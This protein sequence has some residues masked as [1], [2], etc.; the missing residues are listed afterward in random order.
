MTAPGKRWPL[1]HHAG[2]IV[3][4]DR[5]TLPV[6]SIALRYAVSVF[7]GIRLYTHQD[8]VYPWL[9]DQHLDR[10]RNSCH[11]MGLD[12]GA[13]AAVPD[14]ISLPAPAQPRASKCASMA[15]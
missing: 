11:L 7:E 13:C 6:A 4:L 5:A 1:A 3:T 14:I 9:L 10:L 2:E 8:G 12:V 15:W